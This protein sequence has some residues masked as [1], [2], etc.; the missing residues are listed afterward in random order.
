MRSDCKKWCNEVSPCY[1]VTPEQTCSICKEE[2]HL[3]DSLFEA[4]WFYD[5]VPNS[6][7]WDSTAS[8]NVLLAASG[9][10]CNTGA[11]PQTSIYASVTPPGPPLF[12][13]GTYHRTPFCWRCAKW[14]KGVS[15]LSFSGVGS[16]GLTGAKSSE[17]WIF[18]TEVS[19]CDSEYIKATAFLS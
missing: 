19:S 11:I 1:S 7:L 16:A 14:D 12:S 13:V 5:S 9:L 15:S 17:K 10:Q 18:T 2:N 6:G 8:M 3:L 4:K